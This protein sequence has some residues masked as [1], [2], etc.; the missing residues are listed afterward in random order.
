MRTDLITRLA[1]VA[2]ACSVGGC[3][4]IVTGTTQQL[5]VTSSPSGARCDLTREGASLGSVETPNTIEVSK[6]AYSIAVNC[7]G[8]GLRG[9]AIVQSEL[10]A[11]TFGNA[12]VG[13]VVG[14]GVDMATGAAHKYPA[15]VN[16]ILQ[17][18]NAAPPSPAMRR[19]REN[20]DPIS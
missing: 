7:A 8:Q 3:A 18:D 17:P 9:Q 1:V 13:G 10:Q 4:S 16:V 2:I 19:P 20:R 5:A 6:S 11:A 12:L 15:N 14:V